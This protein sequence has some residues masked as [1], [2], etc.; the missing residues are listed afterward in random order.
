MRALTYIFLVLNTCTIISQSLCNIHN[1]GNIQTHDDAQVGFHANLTND[2]IFN[3]NG[4]ETGFYNRNQSLTITGI[5]TPT[6]Y[7]LVTDVPDDLFL[8]VAVDVA[9]FND[10]RN[11]R[12][13]TPRNTPNISLNLLNDNPYIGASD[14]N[15]IDGYMTNSGILDFTFPVGNDFRIRP[16]RIRDVATTTTTRAAYFFENPTTS[17]TF[18]E[19]FDTTKHQETLN[20][21]SPVEYWD[22]DGTEPTTVTLTWDEESNIPF[23]ADE[24]EYLRVVGW[25]TFEEKWIDLGNINFSG[26]SNAGELT[27]ELFIPNNY[28]ALTIGSIL[29]SNEDIFVYTGI[30]PN[31]D[32]KNDFLVIRGIE[33]IPDNEIKIFNRWG[34]L[35]YEK[36][37]YKNVP[38]EAWNGESQGRVTLKGDDLLPVGT[39]F[40]NLKLKDREDITGYIYLQR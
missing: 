9:N 5:N 39:Y 26:D 16:L 40:Y 33:T 30:S 37:N 25:N 27:S 35:V 20:V 2:G 18:V 1:F 15:H 38:E 4:G 11:G 12:I 31:G 22:L 29:K 7:D 13:F 8:E 34:V 19:S 3:E 14:P 23:L 24:L 10:F 21:I 17:S 36:K 28:E 32:E 6:F